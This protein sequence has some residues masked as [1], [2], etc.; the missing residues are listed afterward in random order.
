MEWEVVKQTDNI[1]VSNLN[2]D[3]KKT[4]KLSELL[5]EDLEDSFDHFDVSEVQAVLSQL[6]NDAIDLAH[7]E[8]LMQQ[9]L[10]CADLMSEMIGKLTKTIHFLESKVDSAKNQAALNYESPN[11]SKTTMQQRSWASECDPEV[12]KLNIKLS[13]AKGAKAL[14]DRKYDILIK[15]HHSFKDIANG[16]RKSLPLNG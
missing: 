13:R 3:L 11:S 6:Q 8:Q 15:S 16:M 5:G 4:I 7:A 14:L 1:D 2:N 12:E 9:T 10:R